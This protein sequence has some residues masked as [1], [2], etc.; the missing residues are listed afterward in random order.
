MRR[1]NSHLETARCD[2]SSR[3]AAVHQGD[4]NRGVAE[5]GLP[6]VS[7][8][9]DPE[10]ATAIEFT[11][12]CVQERTGHGENG[13]C[14][15]RAIA[16]L[17]RRIPCGWLRFVHV[18]I[19]A[20]SAW[21]LF[22]GVILLLEGVL[23]L[24][25]VWPLCDDP[26]F[27]PCQAY[28][29][30]MVPAVPMLAL[31]VVGFAISLVADR[32]DMAVVC[33]TTLH[34]L[35]AIQIATLVDVPA[36][37]ACSVVAP[38]HEPP[39]APRLGA[40]HVA[41]PLLPSTAL[42]LLSHHLACA[43]ETRGP[44]VTNLWHVAAYLL[45]SFVLLNVAAVVVVGSKRDSFVAL[46]EIRVRMQ[47][48]QLATDS[49]LRVREELMA[50]QEARVAAET[51]RHVQEMTLGYSAHNLNGP[52]H[53]CRGLCEELA[54]RADLPGDVR[55][56]IRELQSSVEGMMRVTSD[57][58]V[59]QR[60]M[61]QVHGS[62]ITPRP[63]EIGPLLGTLA[64]KA[65]GLL[66]VDVSACVHRAVPPI[67][68]LDQLRVNQIMSAALANAA[69]ASGSGPF[70][71][72]LL[73]TVMYAPDLDPS[74]PD[75]LEASFPSCNESNV[76]TDLRW[77][78]E[79]EDATGQWH[80]WSLRRMGGAPEAGELPAVLE[81][82][83]LQTPDLESLAAAAELGLTA[84][85]LQALRLSGSDVVVATLIA[86]AVRR[87]AQT[88]CVTIGDVAR[89]TR[90]TLPRSVT[91]GLLLPGQEPL[92]MLYPTGNSC[93]SLSTQRR[94]AGS[95]IR[96][97][98]F[99]GVGRAASPLATSY[100][101]ASIPPGSRLPLS[102]L[103]TTT[104]SAGIVGHTAIEVDVTGASEIFGTQMTAPTTIAMGEAVGAGATELFE[105]PSASTAV[106]GVWFSRRPRSTGSD[107]DGSMSPP[108]LPPAADTAAPA[109]QSGV[110]LPRA[111]SGSPPLSAVRGSRDAAAPQPSRAPRSPRMLPRSAHSP[112][113]PGWRWW[114]HLEVQNVCDGLP[115]DVDIR[116]LFRPFSAVVPSR[117]GAHG[118]GASG[119]GMSAGS[120]RTE[121]H[122]PHAATESRGAPDSENTR[123]RIQRTGL[124]L[125][126]ARLLAYLL[127]GRVGLVED[128]PAQLGAVPHGYAERYGSGAGGGSGSCV[129]F[130]LQVPLVL[131]EPS[132]DGSSSVEL[133]RGG[134]G[135]STDD[136]AGDNGSGRARGNSG[137]SDRPRGGG[138]GGSRRDGSRENQRLLPRGGRSPSGAPQGS[139]APNDGTR[140]FA[141]P[142]PSTAERGAR[143]A[144]DLRH[145]GG[146]RRTA[147]S[148]GPT[149]DT[150]APNPERLQTSLPAPKR[151]PS[152]SPDALGT[153]QLHAHPPSARRALVPRT[154]DGEP[155]L[156][157]DHRGSPSSATRAV[158]VALLNRDGGHHAAPRGGG[159]H[160]ADAPLM[161]RSPDSMPLRT[162]TDSPHAAA[163]P[164]G[165]RSTRS[166]RRNRDAEDAVFSPDAH[167][168]LS[169]PWY[170][171]HP[172][173]YLIP[174]DKRAAR[175]RPAAEA[176]ARAEVEGP[177][178]LDLGY[179]GSSMPANASA[180]DDYDAVSITRDDLWPGHHCTVHAAVQA[181]QWPTAGLSRDT[182]AGR[183]PSRPTHESSAA[184]SSSNPRS[185]ALAGGRPLWSPDSGVGGV[186]AITNAPPSSASL[187]DSVSLASAERMSPPLSARQR[188]SAGAASD[189]HRR[190]V[191]AAAVEAATG[192]AISQSTH[193]NG[194]SV[195]GADS[196][197]DAMVTPD[198]TGHRR[199]SFGAHGG[200]LALILP[201]TQSQLPVAQLQSP[202]A[203]L[204]P[205]PLSSE[206]PATGS[207][208]DGSA[209][210]S[211]RSQPHHKKPSV[212]ELLQ[213]Q[214][215]AGSHLEAQLTMSAA[216]LANTASE[217]RRGSSGLSV[218]LPPRGDPMPQSSAST[219]RRTH[220][221]C[222]FIPDATAAVG[223]S[224]QP[225][226]TSS[227]APETGPDTDTG[228]SSSISGEMHSTRSHVVSPL[229]TLGLPARPTL[230]HGATKAGV[231]LREP[232][233]EA[234]SAAP[235]TASAALEGSVDTRGPTAGQELHN[236]RS[237]RGASVAERAADSSPPVHG[238]CSS[239]D[240]WPASQSRLFSPSLHDRHS[241]GDSDGTRCSSAPPPSTV[242]S[243][244][245][246]SASSASGE[247][248]LRP[249]GLAVLVVDDESTVR[250]V[251]ARFLRLLGC[252][253]IPLND[254][255]GAV[256][257]MQRVRDG[258]LPCPD[259]ILMDIIM[260]AVH[261]D[262]AAA[263][264]RA[265]GFES[266]P[267]IAATSNTS[268]ADQR[269]YLAAGFN[270][271][272]TK[273]FDATAIA[274][275]FWGCG[276]RP[277]P[278]AVRLPSETPTQSALSFAGSPGP[279]QPAVGPVGS[280]PVAPAQR[281]PAAFYS[282]LAE[283]ALPDPASAAAFT[284]LFASGGVPLSGSTRAVGAASVLDAA[285][286]EGPA[287][288]STAP[289]SP[290]A[291][292]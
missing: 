176:H 97:A 107:D 60:L 29:L 96:D 105:S 221:S 113:I 266:L 236:A 259:A 31:A 76:V 17:N 193:H 75:H 192:M 269:R 155:L 99:F 182:A 149:A 158:G 289:T 238:V 154:E 95:A 216:G 254:G 271:V 65:S 245:A 53:A 130:F 232:D 14:F 109:Q 56:D 213:R 21:C 206:S 145:V 28:R 3:D 4:P 275:A 133:S 234:T 220:G 102:R 141:S 184:L 58:L 201:S 44:L 87:S 118:G 83:G 226:T 91:E 68:Q 225:S 6:R 165:R 203:S 170:F 208:A 150:G 200:N 214:R 160:R 183:P 110:S 181:H 199:V 276:L 264:I 8:R 288:C 168:G 136:S 229:S 125:P 33:V 57:L 185:V 36:T 90:V 246:T 198:A 272:L 273:P 195:R 12:D 61:S 219:Y 249:F 72:R 244:C 194:P 279:F 82:V 211:Q 128:A 132:G 5:S 104:Q 35:A 100:G 39:C 256:T 94:R 196:L 179:S 42:L 38:G 270:H 43:G 93:S 138:S 122:D 262:A 173:R 32:Q 111:L 156:Q 231:L 49:A 52:L 186:L 13:S 62:P 277:K 230:A 228:G 204:G 250:R 77:L 151:S 263:Q 223:G 41:A 135:G 241:S 79:V 88:Q 147:S 47:Q 242:D 37:G 106:G 18:K 215:G 278:H 45:A 143:L 243:G 73:A 15:V 261:G 50:A 283:R 101:G 258:Q 166:R 10:V 11:I 127:H 103:T 92:A 116:L 142:G 139:S 24:W 174:L 121:A 290:P 59:H 222:G 180:T 210:L 233:A 157:A 265:M 119:A 247:P 54:D 285:L 134:S 146:T 274:G 120:H 218:R 248:S 280:P 164:S 207:S 69:K 137:R 112:H 291:R 159:Q 227:T 167:P 140:C 80:D 267:M 178:R 239:G 27:I 26:T 217:Q 9:Q 190:G 81:A 123:R 240:A 205:T 1:L 235:P 34:V 224:V 71:V 131:P 191:R 292:S 129:R 16:A 162:H 255:S 64:H 161:A 152:K 148:D 85:E 172:R 40:L 175:H 284:R 108:R 257:Y 268:A 89:R 187:H 117:A 188:S 126:I 114:L 86:R 20:S 286:L 25:M 209:R 46:V 144:G 30:G 115:Q 282:S 177:N 260:Q 55:E 281:R 253:S 84:S 189:A 163:T 74:A 67:V 153:T 63:A 212:S 124:G 51:A 70:P 23:A 48:L 197:G 66:G 287:G 19:A 252:T 237:T 2:V 78:R 251:N 202:P 171:L 7:P 22:W 169:D 98:D